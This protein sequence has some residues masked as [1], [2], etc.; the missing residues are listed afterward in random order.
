LKLKHDERLSNFAYVLNVRQ[1]SEADDVLCK[2]IS[3][4]GL[5]PRLLLATSSIDFGSKARGLLR[6]STRPTLDLPLL[7]L[8][9][10]LLLLRASE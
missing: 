8:L 2:M 3:A 9:L 5:K 10:L 7:L 4:E 6:A 1:Y